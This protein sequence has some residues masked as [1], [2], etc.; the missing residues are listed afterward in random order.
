MEEYFCFFQGG[1]MKLNSFEDLFEC[2]LSDIFAVESHL[3]KD[4]PA[5]IKKAHSTELQEALKKHLEET[6]EQVARLNQIFQFLGEKPQKLE[7]GSVM[8]DLSVQATRFLSNNE[9]SPLMDAAIIAMVQRVEHFEIATYGTLREFAD[10]LGYDDE[11]KGLLK[12]SLKE[13][14]NAD[15]ALTKL[16]KG[17]IFSEGINV[18]AR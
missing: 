10:V 12:D 17:G 2:L 15:E 1:R 13:E 16:A 11:I 6:K 4:L 5:L 14:S 8:K 7:W 9:S 18:A 3:V